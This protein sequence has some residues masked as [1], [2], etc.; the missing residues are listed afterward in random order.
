[1]ISFDKELAI[2]SETLKVWDLKY[3]NVA[4]RLIKMFRDGRIF[5]LKCCICVLRI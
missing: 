2:S 5:V 1:M 3:G 4:A